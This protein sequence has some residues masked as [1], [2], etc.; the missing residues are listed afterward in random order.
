MS[1][2]SKTDQHIDS[3]NSPPLL[4]CGLHRSGT[5]FVGEILRKC[6]AHVL[7]EPMNQQ[8]GLEGVPLAY[9]YVGAQSGQY[10]QFIEDALKFKGKWS[11][12][13]SSENASFI[14]SRLTPFLP[15]ASARRWSMLALRQKLAI[16]ARN[17]VWKDPFV[18]LSMPF[19]LRR[20]GTK[21][22]CLIRKPTA[23]LVSTER[24][25]W[26]FD[27]SNLTKQTE[28]MRD[29]GRGIPDEQWALA[30][31]NHAAS[32]ALLW[33]VMYRVVISQ[34]DDGS[35]MLLIKHEDLCNKP[36]EVAAE[37]CAHLNL[38]FGDAAA[39]YVQVHS[40]A[41]SEVGR[42][43]TARNHMRNSA[44]IPDSWRTEI[45]PESEEIMRKIVGKEILACYGN[46]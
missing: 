46:W 9:P 39:R 42:P 43:A 15:G 44:A 12:S 35:A 41:D 14:R 33:K 18:T 23:I 4:I 31:N 24:Q 38:P 22:V 36:T 27:I 13:H 8:Y 5:T 25:G 2:V 37:I 32:I 26:R 6:G 3:S 45:S 11:R 29:H 34:K 10:A 21:A 20:Y 16:P 17:Y 28:L 40:T 19:M 30:H 1:V 7:H